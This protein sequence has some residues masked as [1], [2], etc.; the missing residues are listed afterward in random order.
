MRTSQRYMLAQ[1]FTIQ[2]KRHKSR[3]YKNKVNLFLIH[4]N[5]NTSQNVILPKCSTLIVL[6]YTHRKED[7]S[8]HEDRTSMVKNGPV[9]WAATVKI[10]PAKLDC[11]VKNGP[12]QRNLHKFWFPKAT[13]VLRTFWKAYQVYFPMQQTPPHLDVTTKSYAQISQRLLR[14]STTFC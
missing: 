2:Q 14:R 12:A 4:F 9:D 10:G 5:S 3:N 11:Y 8:D 13:K 7:E 1:A 6:R